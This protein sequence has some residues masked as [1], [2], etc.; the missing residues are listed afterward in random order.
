[1]STRD[2]RVTATGRGWTVR[3]GTGR[4]WVGPGP[5]GGWAAYVH[6]SGQIAT[7]DTGQLV[8]GYASADDLIRALLT[9]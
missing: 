2:P 9:A 5:T 3:T 7:T 1:M 6:P 4:W 8:T